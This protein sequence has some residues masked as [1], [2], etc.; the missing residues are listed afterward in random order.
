[1]HIEISD[2]KDSSVIHDTM[3]LIQA[4]LEE[5]YE[6]GYRQGQQD[7]QYGFNRLTPDGRILGDTGISNH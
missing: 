6:L 3:A 5:A 2:R 4:K 1:M 7:Y